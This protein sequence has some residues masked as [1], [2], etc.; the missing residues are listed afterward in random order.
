MFNKIEEE[1]GILGFGFLGTGM[2]SE[3]NQPVLKYY[4]KDD[5][6][7]PEVFCLETDGKGRCNISG[8]VCPRF[9][10]TDG[11]NEEKIEPPKPSRFLRNTLPDKDNEFVHNNYVGRGVCSIVRDEC[12]HYMEYGDAAGVF[13]YCDNLIENGDMGACRVCGMCIRA[14]APDGP[15]SAIF[16]GN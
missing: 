12:L 14:Y 4:D 7:G 13:T 3:T 8:G 15:A 16:S 6:D 5:A 10:Y 2:C 1:G 9:W 11:M